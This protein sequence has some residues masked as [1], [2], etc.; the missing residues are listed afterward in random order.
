MDRIIFPN[1]RTE[2]ISIKLP[3]GTYLRQMDLLKHDECG[4]EFLA[5]KVF[6]QHVEWEKKLPNCIYGPQSQ[7]DFLHRECPCCGKIGRIH[8]I[9][10]S[11][12]SGGGF[13]PNAQ[14]VMKLYLSGD[15]VAELAK[16]GDV[17]ATFVGGGEI[18]EYESKNK[19]NPDGTPAKEKKIQICVALSTEEERFWTP[20]ATTMRKIIAKFGQA[21]EDWEGHKVKL[22]AIK[23]MIGGQQK[24]VV[25]GEPKD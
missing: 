8:K 19:K 6:D 20:N 25:Y 5:G 4:K 11:G 10:A 24:L 16:G 2:I 17:I 9:V 18:V 21:T 22:E 13:M 1:G 3:D 7:A 23:Q 15:E 14:D 12:N